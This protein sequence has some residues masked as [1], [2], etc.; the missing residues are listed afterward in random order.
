[1]ADG[2]RWHVWLMPITP[3]SGS[4]WAG[5]FES[6]PDNELSEGMLVF[7]SEVEDEPAVFVS[8]AGCMGAFVARDSHLK[9]HPVVPEPTPG[10]LGMGV[11]GDE[12]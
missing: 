10:S 9:A 8:L 11:E 5:S 12:S 7:Q 2:E 4:V 6:F 3:G 1:M